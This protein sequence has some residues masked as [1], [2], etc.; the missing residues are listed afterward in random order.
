M[1][2]QI[3]T[4]C[5][6][7]LISC[8]KESET[9]HKT[10]DT[11]KIDSAQK[12]EQ[13]ATETNTSDTITLSTKHK[14]NKILCDLDGDGL[15]ETVEIVRGKKSDKSGLRISFGNG[16]RTDYFGMGT[17]ILEQGF[18]EIDWAGIFE[19][20]SKNELYWNNVN[21]DGEI[22]GDEEIK[23][24][25]KIKLPNDGIFIHAEESCGGGIIYLKNGKYEW[26]Q[27]E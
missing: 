14:T 22:M 16:K 3:L 19:K 12:P 7:L 20:A 17:T 10:T 9:N 15:N 27:Q 24:E 5:L 11:V 26:I 21:E 13:K 23:E 4:I 1:R 25:D 8:K 18:D 6:T 2:I